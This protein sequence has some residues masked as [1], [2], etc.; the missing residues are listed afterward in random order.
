[1]KI[2]KSRKPR[3]TGSNLDYDGSHIFGQPFFGDT[4]ATKKLWER[5]TLKLCL[6]CGQ[7]DCRCKSKAS[8]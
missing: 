7:K 5:L 3:T 4:P 6:G 8:N 1:M 2:Q